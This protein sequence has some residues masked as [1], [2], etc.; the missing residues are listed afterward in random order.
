MRN[1]IVSVSDKRGLCELGRALRLYGV[2]ILS[3][4]GTLL[5]LQKENIGSTQVSAFTGAPEI[6]DGRVKTLHPVVFAN[7]LQRR[8]V[9][10]DIEQMRQAGYSYDGI[11]FVIVNLYPFK[12]TVAKPGV[13]VD[14]AIENIDIGGPSMLRAAAKNFAWVC[15]I[16][17][18]NDYPLLIEELVTSGGTTT[19]E[20]RKR[21]AKK[22]FAHTRDYDTAIAAYFESI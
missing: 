1:A 8:D 15:V 7:I 3:T 18:P 5:A 10:E 6:M 9:P 13:T 16:V 4:G 17:D 14:E 20:F 21:M 19:L 2:N 12:E 11:D 22:V